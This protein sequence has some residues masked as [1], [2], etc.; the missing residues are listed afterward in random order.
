MARQKRS[1][2]VLQKAERRCA[3]L[4]SVDPQLDF[5]DDL[6]IDQYGK[7][8]DT[9]RAQIATYN[10]ALSHAD[11]ACNAVEATEQQLKVLSERLL[12]AVAAKYGKDSSEYEMA[13]GT[14]TSER[15]R[16]RRRVA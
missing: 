2:S 9:L 10:Q 4:K 15:K 16:S 13:G 1:S 3:G 11:H 14:R 6:T 5:G 12:M 8:I 7:L